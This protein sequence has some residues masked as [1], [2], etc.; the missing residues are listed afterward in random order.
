MMDDQMYEE[1]KERLEKEGLVFKQKD[2]VKGDAKLKQMQFFNRAYRHF[3]QRQEVL[4]QISYK[5]EW[6]DWTKHNLSLICYGWDNVRHL[7][8]WTYGVNVIQDLPDDKQD[9]IN[10]L[11]IHIIDTLFDQYSKLWEES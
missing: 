1:L 2:S 10:D 11:A 5:R 4:H 9:E 8:C 6:G 3:R 7:V